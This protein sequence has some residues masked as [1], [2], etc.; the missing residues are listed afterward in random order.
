MTHPDMR[1]L[2]ETS[3]ARETSD[4]KKCLE[5]ALGRTVDL[6]A[7][8]YGYVNTAARDAVAN[9]G[10][11]AAFSQRPGR[12]RRPTDQFLIERVGVDGTDSLSAFG[13]KVRYGVTSFRPRSL[14]RHLAVSAVG[15]DRFEGWRS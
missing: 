15:H 1:R 3:L 12:N 8:P 14:A 6:F 11:T 13:T 5:D 4:S 7:Y 10:Y 2:D 9:A